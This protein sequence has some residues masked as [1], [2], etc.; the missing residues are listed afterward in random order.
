MATIELICLG[1][2]YGA[3]YVLRGR[4]S[5]AFAILVDEVPYL[6]VDCGNGIA[7]SCQRHLG[8]IPSHIYITHN[9][10]DHTGDF[11]HALYATDGEP[12]IYGHRHVLAHVKKHRLH[13]SPQKQANIIRAVTWIE[14]ND[15]DEVM[16]DHE[17]KLHLHRSAHDYDT[18]GFL[19]TYQQRPILGYTADCAYHEGIY[20]YVTRAPIALIDARDE[21][22]DQH[23]AM[24][25]VDDYAQQTPDCQIYVV[26]YEQSNYQFAADN[27]R[28][29]KEADRMT[30]AQ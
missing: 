16:L 1:V 26:H 18:Y 12:H 20:E 4:P 11:P 10:A 15:N 5:T 23:A 13:D 21:G 2:G 8:C 22:D 25:Q 7:L 27:A 3:S 14:A 28:L 29:L 19:M 6:L 30:L 9:H 24:M 17:L